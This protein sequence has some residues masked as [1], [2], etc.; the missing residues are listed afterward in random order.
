MPVASIQS[1]EGRNVAGEHSNVFNMIILCVLKWICL[2]KKK[3]GF[4]DTKI[5]GHF[6]YLLIT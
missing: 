5:E 6:E 3:G 1:F 4:L 2:K